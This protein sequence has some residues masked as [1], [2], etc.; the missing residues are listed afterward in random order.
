MGSGAW[1]RFRNDSAMSP[2]WCCDSMN[3]HTGYKRLLLVAQHL[4]KQNKDVLCL[5]DKHIVPR[6][7]MLCAAVFE[8]LP[9][10]SVESF[11]PFPHTHFMASPVQN[12]YPF[13]AVYNIS[14]R[15]QAAATN[16]HVLDSFHCLPWVIQ[17]TW[18]NKRVNTFVFHN[19]N[20]L[21]W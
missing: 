8:R 10:L 9:L 17:S 12:S 1:E 6:R 13:Y 4:T 19:L 7:R 5:L 21:F 18:K 16:Q 3:Y 2:D 11:M 20:V 14:E 15:G